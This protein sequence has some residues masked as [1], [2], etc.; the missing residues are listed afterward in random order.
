MKAHIVSCILLLCMS[1]GFCL[2]AAYASSDEDIIFISLNYED[3]LKNKNDVQNGRPGF[4]GAYNKLITSASAL[5]SKNPFKVTDGELPPSGDNHDFYTIAKY[6]WPNPNTPDGMP[7]YTRDG[8]INPESSDDKYDLYRF[9]K[10]VYNINL[11]TMAWFYSGDER[12]AAK[13]AEALRVWFINDDTRMNPNFNCAAALPGVHN[14]T[15][16]GVIFGVTLINMLDYVKLL[17]LSDSWSV[18]DNNN[19]K[20]WFSEYIIWLQTSTFGIQESNSTNNHVT[21]YSAQIAS[22]AIYTGNM[23]LANAMVERGK[24]HIDKQIVSDGSMPRELTRTKSFHYSLYGLKAFAALANCGKAIGNNLWDYQTADGRGLKKAYDFLIPYLLKL[25]AWTWQNIDTEEADDENRV[26]AIQHVRSAAQ[27]YSTG[28]LKITEDYIASI[29]PPNSEKIYLYGRNSNLRNRLPLINLDYDA[30]LKNKAE[31]KTGKLHLIP[32]YQK[33]ITTAN[34]ILQKTPL[35]V[36]DGATPPSGNDHDFYTISAYAWPNPNTPDGMPYIYR[37]GYINE[38]ADGDNYDLNRY[39]TTIY[40]VRMLSLA[41]FFSDDE[42]YANKAAEILRVWFINPET[43]MNPSFNYTSIIPGV[44]DGRYSGVIYGVSLINLI[45][46]VNL[47]CLSESWTETDNNNLKQWF[48]DYV[49]WLTTSNFG[50]QESKATNNHGGWYNAQLARFS[51]YTD[52]ISLANAAIEKGKTQ[53]SEQMMS[54]GSLPRELERTRS[55]HYSLYGLE[56]FASLA[57]C[58][59]LTGN[60]LWNYQA[61]NGR[62][63]KKGFDFIVPYLIKESTWTWMD[64]DSEAEKNNDRINALLY[65]RSAA[66]IFDTDN[67]K[68][69]ENYITSLGAVDNE[70]I[71]L[72]GRN[73]NNVNLT[74]P[75]IIYASPQGNDNNDGLSWHNAK[76]TLSAAYSACSAGGAIYMESGTYDMSVPVAITRPINVYGG[77][78]VDYENDMASRP[79]KVNGKPWEFEGGTILNGIAYTGSG[80]NTNSKNSRLIQIGTSVYSGSVMF[81][82]IIFQNAQGK[83]SGANELGGAISQSSGTSLTMKLNNCLFKNNSVVKNDYASGGM[84][85]ALYIR[86]NA[87][88]TNCCFSGNSAHIGSSG[89]GAIYSQPTAETSVVT[90]TGCLFDSNTSNVSGAGIRTN[91]TKKTIINKCIFVNNLASDGGTLKNAAAL[92]CSGQTG[93]APSTDEISN[94]LFYNNSGSTSVV[95]NGTIMKNCTFANNIGNIR[96]G[97]TNAGRVY[98]TVCWGNKKSDGVSIGGFEFSQTPELI[99][100]CASNMNISGNASVSN[101]I[102]LSA[103]NTAVNGPKFKTPT[104]FAGAGYL[105]GEAPDWSLSESSIL[106]DAGSLVNSGGATDIAGNTRAISGITCSIGAYESVGITTVL[107]IN[108]LDVNIRTVGATLL[109]LGE[110]ETAVKVFNTN[111][112]LIAVAVSALNHAIELTRG[113]YIVF[114]ENENDHFS[115]KIIIN[116]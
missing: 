21:W 9:D 45:D 102:L 107:E 59:V 4:T 2:Q 55:F 43:R 113:F 53:V 23:N 20:Q 109:V 31:V 94:C 5:L 40:Y 32:V 116:Y 101:F 39:N 7:Y 66:G 84:G 73:K 108:S 88:I 24:N 26:N 96:M 98:N 93:T 85:G 47:L 34:T 38:E 35:T 46:F 87:D 60:D 112:Q 110:N 106:K 36:T 76:Q 1:A 41:W 114:V 22:Y 28:Q 48:S 75:Q 10:T 68:N 16:A 67:L 13:A 57:N 90:I 8:L 14:G 99:Q 27:L 70:K 115:T 82:G 50:I 42:R 64:I 58:G 81:D 104:N 69:T 52:N 74:T 89:G 25:K 86:E 30:L 103:D 83:H 71:W 54:D 11:L 51:I 111:G 56:A 77:F 29:A 80:A 17:N 61:L 72:M 19:L 33:L 15:Y 62:S 97:Y 78:I 100:N 92:Y 105:S 65:L 37:D 95:L 49:Q 18:T 3:L 91:G 6:A 44:T 12:Y 79:L 63:L